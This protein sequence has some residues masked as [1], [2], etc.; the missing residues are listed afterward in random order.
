MRWSKKWVELCGEIQFGAL[1]SCCDCMN[2]AESCQNLTPE[3]WHGW[4]AKQTL[5]PSDSFQCEIIKW[6]YS[7]SQLDLW[8]SQLIQRATNLRLSVINVG[9]RQENWKL[10]QTIFRDYNVL[11]SPMTRPWG[12]L[13]NKGSFLL[14]LVTNHFPKRWWENRK[15]ESLSWALHKIKLFIRYD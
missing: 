12:N 3:P 14:G 4:G 7:H 10:K 9:R 13:Q 6:C 8:V 11:V 2:T 15:T 1:L 5:K